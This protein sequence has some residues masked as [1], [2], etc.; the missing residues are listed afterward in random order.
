M[1]NENKIINQIDVDRS[2]IV[3]RGIKVILD[4]D[5]AN[6]YQVS[7]KR[8]N[9]QVKRNRH[10]FPNDFMFQLTDIEKD[11]V[12]ANCDHLNTLRFSYQNPRAFTE[13]GIA[14]L[15]AILRSE[16][17]VAMS[18]FIV[19]AFIKLRE[20]LLTNHEL[21]HKVS[22]LEHTQEKQGE[23]IE[24]INRVVVQ[25]VGARGET[26]EPLGFKEKK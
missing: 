15:S 17:A 13:Y 20:A 5:I 2:I 16:R 9:E 4:V 3:I 18:I 22:E 24:S 14:M 1:K 26:K 11:E 6:L 7:T 12:V 25:L 8:L 10:R 23:K 19:R 21:A